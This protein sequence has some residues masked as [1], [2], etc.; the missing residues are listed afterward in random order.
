MP[1]AAAPTQGIVLLAHGSR[2]PD[3]RAPIEALAA[4]MVQLAPGA[5]IACAYLEF[6]APD[7]PGAVAALLRAGAGAI[8]IQPMFL[9]LGR[10]TRAD[11]PRLLDE[12]RR[13][14]PGVPFTLRPAIA[15]HPEVLLAMARA[16]LDTNPS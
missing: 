4:R 15:E 3:W 7:L 5:R 12:Q 16:A 8:A 2:D 14:Y 9:G 6:S 10:H 11:L 1:P 13:R